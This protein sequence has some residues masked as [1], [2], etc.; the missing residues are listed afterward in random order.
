MPEIQTNP[1][2]G[3]IGGGL[4][5]MA[6][7]GALAARG[8]RVELFERRKNLG[9]R[10]SSFYEPEWS[11]W[12]DHCR[13]ASLGCCTNLADFCRR[14]D[15]A[16][17]FTKH[18]MLNFIGPDGRRYRFTPSRWLPAPLHLAPALWR[19]RLL[20][21]DDRIAIGR[22]LAQLARRLPPNERE[23]TM[24]TWLR[25]HG[26]S[27]RAIELFW[28]TVLVSALSESLDRIAVPIARKVFTDGMMASRGAHSM[29]LPAESLHELFHRRGGDWLAKCGVAL[30]LGVHVD[31]ALLAGERAAGVVLD[32]GSRTEFDFLVLAV[33]WH[34]VRSLLP[35]ALLA[36]LPEMAPLARFEAAPITS[37]HLAYDRPITPLPHAVLPGRLSQWLFTDALGEREQ[38]CEVV[39]S[40]SHSVAE[41]DREAL[42]GRVQAEL[43][44]AFPA[45]ATAKLL[46]ARAATHPSAVFSPLPGIEPY[47]PAQVSSVEGL[48][49]AGDWTATGW[50]ATMESAVRSG[51]L[52][53]EGVLGA[54]GRH[55]PLLAPD[56]P[57]D[58][59]ARWA[60]GRA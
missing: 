34:K 56:L 47:R 29:Y 21:M 30:R 26:Q 51:Y 57:R 39:I 25:W 37:V 40:A 22:A 36:R 46:R 43:A 14:L 24:A 48:F 7:A 49:F 2:V 10:A 4:A 33:P 27:D 18:D 20:S 3:V 50:P 52:A 38:R 55:E 42:I 17:A 44:A 6:A 58:R 32:G 23:H 54:L 11:V 28:K 8:C 12:I 53:A 45:A 13:H 1:I 19:L 16:D 41:L 15:G 59:L 5:G 60:I 35:A 9:G 31:H